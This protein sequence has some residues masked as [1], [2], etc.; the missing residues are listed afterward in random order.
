[1]IDT[2]NIQDSISSYWEPRGRAKIGDWGR[3]FP[4]CMCRVL[5]KTNES[6]SNTLLGDPKTEQQYGRLMST[7][8]SIVLRTLSITSMHTSPAPVFSVNNIANHMK[9]TDANGMVAVKVCLHYY[10]A[11]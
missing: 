11:F 6:T 8:R 3:G 4:P 9:C 10:D 1:M 2:Y 7:L 5:G